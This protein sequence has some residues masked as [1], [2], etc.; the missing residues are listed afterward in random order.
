MTTCAY[1]TCDNTLIATDKK[2]YCSRNCQVAAY[3]RQHANR[4]SMTLAPMTR[5]RAIALR[6]SLALR[7]LY[8]LHG[9][10][11]PKVAPTRLELT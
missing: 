4:T 7:H 9:G 3:R 10:R 5:R 1:V 6:E 8:R 2:R 11:I